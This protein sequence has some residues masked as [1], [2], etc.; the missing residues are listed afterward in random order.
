MKIYDR[1]YKELKFPKLILELLDC[2]GLLRLR[3]VRMANNQFVAFPSFSTATRYE[4]SLGV[5]YLA[6]ICA[7]ALELDERE[8][9]ELMIACLYHDVGTPPFAHAMEEVLQAKFGFDHEVNLKNLIIG[10]T[11]SFDGELAQIYHGEGL[12]IRSVCQ[13]SQAR[14]LG[15]DIFRIAKLAAGDRNE[16]L[17]PLINSDGMDLDNIDNIIRA[18]SA[19][20]ILS[21]ESDEM[22]KNLANA[23]LRKGNKIYYNGFYSSEIK[24]WQK[25][26]D[27]QYTAIFESIDDFSYQ[28][29]IK[30]AISLL[31]E[32]DNDVQKLDINSWRLTDSSITYNYL[33]KHTKSSQIMKRVLLNKPFLCIGVLYVS[34]LGVS[35]YINKNIKEIEKEAGE[36]YISTL[37]IS[38]QKINSNFLE[39]I[40]ANFYP[41]KRKRQIKEKAILWNEEIAI[42]EQ[43]VLAQGALLGLFTPYSNSNFKVVEDDNDS[44]RKSV[45]FRR[46]DLNGM[47]EHLEKGI[48]QQYKVTVYGGDESGEF[49]TNTESNQ[50][51]LF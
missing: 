15:I 36:Y 9:L 17:S 1:L 19:M 49:I 32:E 2:P 4:H 44:K 24:K 23:F 47:I 35:H 10:N 12:K 45:S 22:A 6:G 40:I 28:T 51:G 26:R 50:L 21:F 31:L 29:M 34:G 14:K 3:E 41:D 18:T 38:E 13:S 16:V 30:K 39:P 42:D 43:E 48:L 33:L 8:T 37:G 5:C 25:I 46:Q 20:G 27:I 11:G 7:K